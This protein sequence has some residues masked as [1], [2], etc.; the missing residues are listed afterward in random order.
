MGDDASDDAGRGEA[1][2]RA[3]G[4]RGVAACRVVPASK[5]IADVVVIEEVI[6]LPDAASTSTFSFPSIAMAHT[7]VSGVGMKGMPPKWTALLKRFVQVA[8]VRSQPGSNWN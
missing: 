5:A 6:T 4:D 3:V 2:V 1:R 7:A 8:S